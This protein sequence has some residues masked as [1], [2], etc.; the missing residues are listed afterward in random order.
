[1]GMINEFLENNNYKTQHNDSSV[2]MIFSEKTIETYDYLTENCEDR[3]MFDSQTPTLVT[4][5]V[6]TENE[7]SETGNKL[8]EQQ[9]NEEESTISENE[10]E[11]CFTM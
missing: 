2:E 1:M 5:T 3:F 11:N 4:L 7:D 10:E 6:G 8:D 9:K